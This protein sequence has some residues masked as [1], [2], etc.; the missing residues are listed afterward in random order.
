MH[1][2]R[3]DGGVEVGAEHG[4][5]VEGFCHGQSDAV[6]SAAPEGEDG[7]TT[8]EGDRGR[9]HRGQVGAGRMHLEPRGVQVLLTEEVVP[10]NGRAGDQVSAA[11]AGSERGGSSWTNTKVS[12]TGNVASSSRRPSPDD[13]H[14]RMPLRG[15]SIA[16]LAVLVAA[17]A[18]HGSVCKPRAGVIAASSDLD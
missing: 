7:F 9:D 1:A 14:G 2:R 13:G 8:V 4:H 15:G 11:C 6:A 16:K 3:A 17:P 18:V 12:A 5:A 10:L